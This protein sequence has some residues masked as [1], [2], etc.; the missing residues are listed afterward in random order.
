[1]I[2]TP[3]PHNISGDMALDNH[4]SIQIA[5]EHSGDN[6]QYLRRLPCTGSI[7]GLTNGQVWLVEIASL[8]AH[9]PQVRETDDSQESIM[10]VP[11]PAVDIHLPLC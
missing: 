3:D 5:A 7:E 6:L 1:M 11:A 10:F 8:D 2:S 4:A 9:L